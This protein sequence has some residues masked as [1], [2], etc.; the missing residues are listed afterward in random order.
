[1]PLDRV[2]FVG[3]DLDVTS[4]DDL[5]ALRGALL[6]RGE[7]LSAAHAG[8]GLLVR[9]RLQG[10][11][12]FHSNLLRAETLPGLL[13]DLRETN[14]ANEP[15]VFWEALRDETRPPVDREAILA[16]GDFTAV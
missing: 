9:A 7:A 14:E 12:T 2:R 5:G 10:R 11:P 1:M 13:Q 4:L 16:R 8:R 6:E 15:F 3:L